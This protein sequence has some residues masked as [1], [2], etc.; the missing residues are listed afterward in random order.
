VIPHSSIL[1]YAGTAAEAVLVTVCVTAMAYYGFAIYAARAFFRR[2]PK[3]LVGPFPPVTILKPLRGLDREA[4]RNF[5]SFCR[6]DYP[7][8]QVV[9]GADDADEPALE[10]ARA[11]ARDFPHV[12]VSI[13]VGQQTPGANPKIGNLS[14]MLSAAKHPVLLVSDSD[15]RVGPSHLRTM[16]QPLADPHVGVATCLYSSQARGLAGELDA[17]SLSTEFQPSVLVARQLEGITFAMGSGICI[18]RSVLEEIGGFNAIADYLADDYFLGN[19]PSRAG[20]A[21]ELANHVVEHRLDT[22]SLTG[23]IHHQIRWNRGTR[24]ARPW[25]YAG[26][27]FTHGV[28]AALLLPFVATGSPAAWALSAAT[29]AARVTMAWYVAVR[30]L[31]DPVARR[32]LWLVPVR[33]LLG[34][35]LWIGAY[36]GTTIVW[37]GQRFRLGEGGRL[38]PSLPRTPAATGE[39]IAT[40]RAVS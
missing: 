1:A 7:E 27:L 40:T 11:V 30:R 36:L 8:F 20:H 21:V 31:R 5:A 22:E 9:F 15:I 18:R 16:V 6:Q 3:P 35:A 33:D 38:E 2:P 19:L 32:A 26:L 29:L 37:R 10:V 23:L 4:Y 17:L 12:D 14:G 24:A 25:G 28:P 13:V 39:A 34:F